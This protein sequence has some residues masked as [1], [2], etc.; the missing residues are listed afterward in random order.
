MKKTLQALKLLILGLILISSEISFGQVA[1]PR[2][3]SAIAA[4]NN[5]FLTTVGGNTYY[6]RSLKNTEHDGNWTLDLDIFGMQDAYQRTGLEAQKTIVN[7]LCTSF[8]VLEKP[9]YNY[10]GWNDDLAWMGLGYIWGYK[11]TGTLSLLTAAQNTFDLAYSRGWNTIFND[12]GIWEQQPDM[13]PADGGINKEA[14]A[15]NPNGNIAA[16]I[17]EATG[18]VEYLNKA[19]TIYNWSRSHIFNPANGQVYTGVERNGSINYGTAVYNQ[20]SF[21]DFAVL[22]YKLT[23]NGIMLQDAK[24]AANY[25][26]NNLTTNGIISN[27][28]DYLN[29][30]ADTYVR[31]VGHLCMANPELWKTYYPFLLNNAK[32]A[33]ANRRKDLNL[34]WNGWNQPT[35]IDTAGVPTKYVS[36]VA[37]MQYTPTLQTIP[38]TIESEDY[39]YIKG[40]TVANINANEKCVNYTKAGNW[41]EYIVNV[42]SSG[43]YTFSFKI[44]GNAGSLILQQN[45]IS[46][47]SINFNGTGDLQ[48]YATISLPVKLDMGIQSVK[49]VAKSGIWNLDKMTISNCQLI[50][51]SLTVNSGTAQAI[52]SVKVDL[53][54]EVA[55]NPTPAAGGSWSWTGPNSY[56]ATSRQIDIT[57]IQLNQGGVYRAQY[58]NTDGCISVQDF[59]ITLN[60]CIPTDIIPSVKINDGIWQQMDAINTITGNYVTIDTKTIGGSV[61]WTEPNGFIANTN[62]I[63]LENIGYKQAGS[64]TATF[65]N[66]NGCTSTKIITISLTGVDPCSLPINPYYQIGIG[67]WVNTNFGAVTSGSSINFGPQP[68]DGKWSWTGPNSYT[69]SVREAKITKFTADSAGHY[70]AT[71]TSPGGCTSTMDFMMGIKGC[72]PPSIIP[73]ISVNSTPWSKLDSIKL[74]SGGNILITPPTI[75]GVWKWTGP[76]SYTSTTSEIS[77]NKALHWLNGKYTLSFIDA[78]L[79]Y[80]SYNVI[81]N[82]TGDDYCA[83]TIIPYIN[84]GGWKKDSTATLNLGK[85][86]EFGPQPNNDKGWLW[87]GPTS[88]QLTANK[89]KRDFTLTGLTAAMTGTYKA[90]YTNT[91]GC[92]STKDFIIKVNSGVGID[93]IKNDGNAGINFFP[94]PAKNSITITG[95][96]S[97]VIIS[98]IDINGK[99]VLNQKLNTDTEHVNIDLSNLQNGTYFIK[100]NSPDNKPLKL[101]KQ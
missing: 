26:I 21:I 6:K 17:Y 47:D 71:Y 81:I 42:P 25:V 79:C 39:N 99:V 44:A 23:G 3:D 9:P 53:G 5:A 93:L 89:E 94:N 52:T 14:L 16:M 75:A 58:T 88:T 92:M 20:G 54:D 32:S 69:S 46:L 60:T 90:T 11:L 86:I 67:S 96:T 68:S 12:G 97:N 95:A 51:P 19:L 101:I 24:M 33:W 37:L 85:S 62:Q 82:V 1:N 8:L 77:F 73:D 43:Y 50:V 29:T 64:Y 100:T 27:N 40:I 70:I 61:S 87:T 38:G 65:V 2:A 63:S 30:W 13:T 35:K 74:V 83:T 4:F 55:F 10:D 57:N 18:N 59:T 34:T 48:T 45:N 22:M 15:N 36:A 84:V 28:A 76:N 72:V 31:G 98:I 56:S 49:V 66:S 41:E 91:L 80:T 78:N 7:N